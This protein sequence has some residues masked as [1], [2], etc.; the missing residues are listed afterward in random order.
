MKKITTLILIASLI[1]FGRIS[2][3]NLSLY[4]ATVNLTGP[5]NQL[6]DAGV[7]VV[8]SSSNTISVK[9]ARTSSNLVAGHITYFCWYLCYGPGT[10]VSPDS[11]PCFSH[12]SIFAFHGYVNANNIPG[13]S[14]VCY[15]FFN[16]YNVSDSVNLCFTYNFTPVGINEAA[17]LSTVSTAYP[18]PADGMTS[19]SYNTTSAKDSRIVI[20][21]LLG[22][23]VKEIKLA[24]K[25]GIVILSTSDFKSGVY[26]YS[27]VV[28][29]KSTATK[30]LV[31]SHR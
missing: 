18:N 5:A 26:F 31:V 3:Q 8:N 20:S 4:G 30:K 17:D 2:A 14:T 19:I 16:M 11:I 7:I 9:C 6:L 24:N 23:T 22:S 15:S 27:L 29:G 13:T 28:D 25:Q 1:S 10:A 12:D 21:N